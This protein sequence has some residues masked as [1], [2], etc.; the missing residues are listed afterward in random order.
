MRRRKPRWQIACISPPPWPRACLRQSAL[1][2][3]R[4]PGIFAPFSGSPL[5]KLR[6]VIALSKADRP[7]QRS[8][9]QPGGVCR[10]RFCVCVIRAS[11]TE[12][13][14]ARA[15][16]CTGS[17][18]PMIAEAAALRPFQSLGRSSDVPEPDMPRTRRRS[19]FGCASHIRM[20]L[21]PNRNA[22]SRCRSYS[23]VCSV[24][25]GSTRSPARYAGNTA[26]TPSFGS[27][28]SASAGGAQQVLTKH[29][30]Q[31]L[32]VS[33]QS[34]RPR[35]RR[36]PCLPQHEVPH[37]WHRVALRRQQHLEDHF[38]AMQELQ[39]DGRQI[40]LPHPAESF[41]G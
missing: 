23:D 26:S 20:R 15:D 38:R 32:A 34:P 1:S 12:G 6:R 17:F 11:L 19:S 28:G 4:I 18:S 30:P 10:D 35:G 40:E 16:A 36:L 8:A 31:H 39:L 27:R 24:F 29:R 37:D 5:R 2:P 33:P 22:L 14:N 9:S 3:R 41:V 13:M 21:R 7:A 25:D